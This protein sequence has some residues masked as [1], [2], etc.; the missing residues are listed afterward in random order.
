MELA[1]CL[2]R[3]NFI[4]LFLLPAPLKKKMAASIVNLKWFRG[5][6]ASTINSTTI[7]KFENENTATKRTVLFVRT[8]RLL[9]DNQL[10]RPIRIIIS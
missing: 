4:E 1:Q 3:I 9:N 6:C 7:T 10:T 5:A 8:L 2:L